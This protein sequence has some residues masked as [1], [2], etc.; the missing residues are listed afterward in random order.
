MRASQVELVVKNPPA[1][2]GDFK[3]R[4]FNPWVGKIPWRRAWQPTP[5]FLPG[6]SHG[7]R[8]LGGLQSMGLQRVRHDLSDLAHTAWYTFSYSFNFNLFMSLDLKYVSYKYHIARF[9]FCIH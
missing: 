7:W 9:Y 5:V 1:N 8:S 2:A 4:G 6:E 3:R